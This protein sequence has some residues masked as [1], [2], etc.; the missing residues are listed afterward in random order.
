MSEIFVQITRR[1]LSRIK[2]AEFSGPGCQI[3]LRKELESRESS[4]LR[5][6]LQAVDR[7]KLISLNEC[8]GVT[9]RES[10]CNHPLIDYYTIGT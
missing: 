5:C 8:F 2:R 1:K 10:V 6:A 3:F 9:L 4:D 7:L